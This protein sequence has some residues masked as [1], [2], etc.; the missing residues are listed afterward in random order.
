[1]SPTCGTLA[2]LGGVAFG[3]AIHAFSGSDGVVLVVGAVSYLLSALLAWRLPNLG[4]EFEEIGSAAREALGNVLRGLGDAVRHLPPL[5][6]LAL[7]VVGAGQLPYGVMIVGTI[8]LF[9]N[10]FGQADVG[11]GLA[12]FAVVVGASGAGYALAALLTPSM[13]RRLGM[14]RYITTLSILAAVMVVFPTA[15]LTR[16]AFV[17]SAFGLAIT[18]QGVKICVDTTVQRVVDD[19]YRGRVFALYDV[20]FNGVFVA[21]TALAA[22]ILPADGPTYA[23]LAAASLWYL[24]I[25]CTVFRRWERPLLRPERGHPGRRAVV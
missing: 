10:N 6:R 22:L 1:M 3:G 20:L 18:T 12:G 13:T 17:F 2:Y 4:P 5:G 24:L 23:V 11:T 19:A 21:A 8:L 25:A 9:R 16:W 15:L 7:G 14:R